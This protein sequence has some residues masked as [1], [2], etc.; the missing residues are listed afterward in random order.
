MIP[1]VSLISRWSSSR[2]RGRASRRTVEFLGTHRMSGVKRRNGDDV[3]EVAR[4]T[5]G[6]TDERNAVG[7]AD[8]FVS[9]IINFCSTR[10]RT[11]FY[12][13]AKMSQQHLRSYGEVEKFRERGL[14]QLFRIELDRWWGR[15]RGDAMR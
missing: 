12:T 14:V 5:M 3:Q 15:Q 11:F 6:H 10:T 13:G 4:D 2:S 7:R 8:S 1:G 9:E